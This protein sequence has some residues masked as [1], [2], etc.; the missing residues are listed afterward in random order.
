MSNLMTSSAAAAEQQQPRVGRKWKSLLSPPR[1]QLEMQTNQPQSE[2]LCGEKIA[3]KF[4]CCLCTREANQP[5]I[6][7]A[8]TSLPS[9]WIEEIII[10]IDIIIIITTEGEPT[11]LFNTVV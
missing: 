1:K 4:V 3:S 11:K 10:I 5:T 6:V 2:Q 7:V 9:K 8:S